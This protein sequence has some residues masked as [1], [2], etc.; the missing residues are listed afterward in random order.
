V[1]TNV[2]ALEI[3]GG[4]I[5]LGL[6]II[7]LFF[8]IAIY[9]GLISL[10]NN[11][12]KAWANIDVLLKKRLDL[13]P[14]LVEIVKGYAIYE[15]SVLEEITK[16]RVSA[17]QAEGIPEKARG[18]EAV[19]TLLGSVFALA[20]NYPDLKASDNFLNL[21]KELSTIESQ[22][23]QR[24][25]FYNDSVLLYNTNIRTIPGVIVADFLKYTPR[26]YFRVDGD[27]ETPVRIAI[28]TK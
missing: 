24:R 21:Q 17:L 4:F 20:E 26:E 8:V 7:G 13:I 9:N 14:N 28:G 12:D 3:S 18:S 15:R 22:I 1:E 6:I 5:V 16:I 23:A 19:S 27:V 25:E 11:I 10:R 2:A